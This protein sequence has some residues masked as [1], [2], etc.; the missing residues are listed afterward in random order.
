MAVAAADVI[1]ITGTELAEAVVT[2][3]IA[4][5]ELVAGDCISSYSAERQDAIVKWLAA[6]LVASTDAGG[7][8]V[9]SEKL[10]DASLTFAR[11]TL[12]EGLKGTFYGQQ[13]LALD[14]NG[15]LTGKGRGQASVEVF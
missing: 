13:A 15:C 11:A 9:T 8:S 4:D 7:V 12:G 2:A 1:A 6:H 3:L 10:G 14:T 5:A